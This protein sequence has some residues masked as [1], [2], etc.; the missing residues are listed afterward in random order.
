MKSG[1]VG[2]DWLAVRLNLIE[3]VVAEVI[4]ICFEAVRTDFYSSL[5]N[6]P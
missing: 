6:N 5:S 3:A 1:E 2:A 4:F